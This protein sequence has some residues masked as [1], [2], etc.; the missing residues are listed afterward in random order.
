MVGKIEFLGRRNKIEFRLKGFRIIIKMGYKSSKNTRNVNQINENYEV[1]DIIYPSKNTF[2]LF[3]SLNKNLRLLY[4]PGDE[5][6]DFETI[7]YS[8]VRD[9]EEEYDKILAKVEDK[10]K[11]IKD[12]RSSFLYKENRRGAF[13]ERYQG[14]LDCINEGV[15]CLRGKYENDFEK[16]LVDIVKKLSYLGIDPY[17]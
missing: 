14:I 9:D 3:E 11:K 5:S 10:I 15:H 16:R 4:T 8:E 6:R 2:K 12:F 7:N 17:R 13:Y 1:D